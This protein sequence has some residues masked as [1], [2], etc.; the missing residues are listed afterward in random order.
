MNT[1][2]ERR[3]S[4]NKGRKTERMKKKNKNLYL[5]WKHK[6]INA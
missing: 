1:D 3:Y 2:G 4:I 5:N 6:K